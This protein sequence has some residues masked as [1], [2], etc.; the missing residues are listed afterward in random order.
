[1][2]H[3][4]I[5]ASTRHLTASMV[6]LDVPA[7]RVLLVDHRATE[8][9]VFPGGHI[10]PNETPAEAA[11]REVFEETGIRPRISGQ[12]IELAGMVWH[13]S[14]WMTQEIPAPAKPDRGPGKPAEPPHS[15]IDLLFI[16][17]AGSDQH[18]RPALGEVAS[19][20]W[21]PLA[22]L[23]L[24][25]ARAEVPKVAALAY[26]QLAADTAGRLSVVNIAGDGSTNVVFGN[27]IRY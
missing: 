1:M 24:L 7:K 4:S 14:P 19:A 11:I 18:P 5:T 2:A 13:P 21:V 20:W 6:V 9:W 3:T 25:N 12:P 22:E 23:H 8:Q 26:R 10:D 15:H 27:I 17:E 16:G